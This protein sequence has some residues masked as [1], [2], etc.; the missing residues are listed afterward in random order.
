M[1]LKDLKKKQELNNEEL[2]FLLK[3]YKNFNLY[4]LN[5]FVGDKKL[6]Y[7]TKAME[8]DLAFLEGKALYMGTNVLTIAEFLKNHLENRNDTNLRFASLNEKLNFSLE[9]EM[10]LFCFLRNLEQIVV[11]NLKKSNC[12]S[13]FEYLYVKNRNGELLFTFKDLIIIIKGAS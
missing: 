9:N 3:L 12:K 13:I 10:E 1:K 2:T 8:K 5:I 7:R 6:K 11:K 4:Y